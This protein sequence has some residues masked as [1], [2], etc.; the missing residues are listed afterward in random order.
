M[1]PGKIIDF[2]IIDEHG[3]DQ[4]ACIYYLNF[5]GLYLVDDLNEINGCSNEQRHTD[6]V[7]VDAV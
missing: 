7:L 1:P 6:V 4:G 2:R 5:H 3:P